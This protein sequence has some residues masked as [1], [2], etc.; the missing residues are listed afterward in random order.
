MPTGYT[1]D[2]SEGK[3]V[4][5]EEFTMK[6]ARAFGALVTIRDEPLDAPIPNE[7][8]PSNYHLDAL[9]KAKKFLAKVEKWD[10]VRAEKE[11]KKAFVEEV[12]LVKNS[13]EK[14]VRTGRN[15]IAMLKRAGKWIPPTKDHEGLK[16]FMID[17][18]AD[19]IESDCLHTP[20]MPQRL[21]GKQYRTKLMKSARRDIAYH[22]TKHAEEVE[23]ARER[24]E[25]VRMLRHSLNGSNK[26]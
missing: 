12:S 21:S 14:R 18:L 7:F 24:S 25:W 10:N 9:E 4:G 11:A 6:C 22:T 13:G 19:S 5:F 2:L 20:T 3:Q 1:A 17:Q 26:D 23:R 15:Y 8:Q 16:S